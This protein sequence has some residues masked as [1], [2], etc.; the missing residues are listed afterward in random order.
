MIRIL[1][2][3]DDAAQRF[4]VETM[5]RRAGYE[6]ESARSG[7]EALALLA[8]D[9]Q[10]AAILSDIRMPGMDSNEFLTLLSA[11]YPDIPVIIMTV[12]AGSRWADEAL[13]H[14]AV[15]C[16][17]KPFFGPQLTDTLEAYLP[18]EFMSS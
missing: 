5:L 7:D 3:E 18:R 10:F 8:R 13:G 11:H 1:V 9:S 12:H 2:V 4:L 15:A 16:L 6:T 14:G 17:A